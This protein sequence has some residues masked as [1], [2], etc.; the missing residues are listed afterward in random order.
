MQEVELS[1]LLSLIT[2]SPK[3]QIASKIVNNKIYQ[4]NSFQ[5]KKNLLGIYSKNRLM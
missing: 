4:K 2:R 1:I 5:K 3:N